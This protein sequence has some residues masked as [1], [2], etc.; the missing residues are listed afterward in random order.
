MAEETREEV[1]EM[2]REE[3]REE[4]EEMQRA[5]TAKYQIVEQPQRIIEGVYRAIYE[6]KEISSGRLVAWKRLKLHDEGVCCTHLREV[7]LLKQLSHPN[8]VELLDV[9]ISARKMDLIF[10]YHG[11]DLKYYMRSRRGHLDPATVKSFCFQLCTGVNFCHLQRV[12]H[13]D[14]KPQHLLVDQRGRLKIAG[15]DLA[16]TLSY[17]TTAYT[18]EVVTLWYRP[19][20]LLLGSTHYSVPVDM[21]SVGCILGEMA[22]GTPLF[23]N[24]HDTPSEI[25]IIFKIFQKLGTPTPDMWPGLMDLPHFKPTFPK[26]RAKEWEKIRNTKAQVG[27]AGIDLLEQLLMYDPCKRV[28]ARNALKHPYFADVVLPEDV[29]AE[30]AKL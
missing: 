15:F 2:G 7:A 23:C 29:S 30:E 20:E 6:A 25:D 19:L 11:S 27:T 10:E 18:H 16:R 5:F 28:T 26:W 14:L 24:A 21:W 4:L 22:T 9:F 3:T 12:I 13:R 1:E 17:P 8:V